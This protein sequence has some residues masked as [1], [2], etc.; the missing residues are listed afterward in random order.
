MDFTK[1]DLIDSRQAFMP[2][3][4]PKLAPRVDEMLSKI[5]GKT[6]IANDPRLLA[7]I[8]SFKKRQKRTMEERISPTGKKYSVESQDNFINNPEFIKELKK[9]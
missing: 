3:I 8:V 5:A 1:E 7:L 9:L 4:K 6:I 2:I